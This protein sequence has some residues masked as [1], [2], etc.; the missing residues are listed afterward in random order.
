[1]EC[2]LKGD[3]RTR[4]R[5]GW[6]V[7]YCVELHPDLVKPYYSKLVKLLE[8]PGLH[9]AINRNVLR[10]L[11]YAPLPERY[12]GQ[13]MNA[14]F[15]FISKPETPVAIKAYS[16]GILNSLSVK[17]PAII[18]EIK[19][20]IEERWEQETAAFKSRAMKLLKRVEKNQITRLL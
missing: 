14:C 17:Y 19:L 8:T 16:L 15:D 12:H 3:A 1:M 4:Q 7:G 5:A 18:P 9:P 10:V 11:E 13:V 6:P 20:I 2:F